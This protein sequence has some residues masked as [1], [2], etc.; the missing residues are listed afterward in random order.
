MSLTRGQWARHFRQCRIGLRKWRRHQKRFHRHRGHIG[1]GLARL[2]G[3]FH[4]A[5]GADAQVLVCAVK[6]H[7]M[8]HVAKRVG[9]PPAHA[10]AFNIP[11]DDTLP[12]IRARR[13]TQILDAIARRRFILIHR[14]VQNGE[15]HGV[16]PGR[17]MCVMAP[18]NLR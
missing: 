14:V 2:Q 17:V 4:H 3:G 11:L 15:F 12:R 16:R 7:D 5:A 10:G 13:Q 9:L 18:E 1:D 6:R 8:Y